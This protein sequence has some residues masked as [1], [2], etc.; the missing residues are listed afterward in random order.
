MKQNSSHIILNP[1]AGNGAARRLLPILDK[2]LV[3]KNLNIS[4]HLTCAQGDATKITQRLL[5]EG[6][7]KIVAAG[8]DGTINEVLNGFF[9]GDALLNPDCELGI[10]KCGTGQGLALSLNIPDSL[11]EQLDLIFNS[12]AQKLDVGKIQYTGFIN[13]QCTRYFISESQVG[14][15]SVI[16]GEVHNGFNILNGKTAFAALSLK[17]ALLFKSI[18]FSVTVDDKLFTRKYIG[19]AFGNGSL[20][21]GGMHLTPNARPDDGLINVLFIHQM[22][23][24]HRLVNLSKMYSGNHILTPWFTY[25]SGKSIQVE[26]EHE[27]TVSADGE[28]IGKTPCTVSVIPAAIKVKSNLN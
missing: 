27:T 22:D 26:C 9:E 12:Q 25:V 1:K 7:L 17:H 20:T 15:G 3:K 11:E 21:A 10:I 19:I 4:I 2:L 14:I 23:L 13:E 28:M 16:A 18:P 6:A 5:G 8:G 24:L